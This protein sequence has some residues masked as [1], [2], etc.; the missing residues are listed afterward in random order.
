MYAADKVW[1]TDLDL[2]K[3]YVSSLLTSART[4]SDTC[5]TCCDSSDNV[6]LDLQ[7]CYYSILHILGTGDESQKLNIHSCPSRHKVVN[8]GYSV[9]GLSGYN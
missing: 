2:Q 5:R 8:N 3:Y 4:D 1:I 6:C 9:N 7:N